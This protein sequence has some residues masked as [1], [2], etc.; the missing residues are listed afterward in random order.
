MA[1][2]AGRDA[3]YFATLGREVV[4]LDAAIELVP[5]NPF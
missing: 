3:S 5:P 4:A 1:A 2:G